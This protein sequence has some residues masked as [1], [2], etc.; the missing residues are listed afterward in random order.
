MERRKQLS[1]R[2][3]LCSGLC[4]AFLL[5]ASA[6]ADKKEVR[7]DRLKSAAAMTLV[8]GG[9]VAI[10]KPLGKKTFDRIGRERK[11]WFGTIGPEVSER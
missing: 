7:N 10:Q 5:L 2:I 6:F 11:N 3:A 1:H 4:A 9:L 8:A